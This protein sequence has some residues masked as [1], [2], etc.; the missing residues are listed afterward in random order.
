[1]SPR[2]VCALERFKEC[3]KSFYPRRHWQ[4]CCCSKH[5]KRLKYLIERSA[6]R[7]RKAKGRTQ[8][9]SN[10]ARPH[11]TRFTRI[12]AGKSASLPN[13]LGALARM[14]PEFFLR[15]AAA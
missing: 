2:L 1:M 11:S 3:S 6:M 4:K 15:L 5:Q 10:A 13:V 7:R 14:R 9:A 8:G 12:P